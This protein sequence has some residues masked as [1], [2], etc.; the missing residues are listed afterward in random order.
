[1]GFLRVTVSR[2]WKYSYV[3]TGTFCCELCRRGSSFCSWRD[4]ASVHYHDCR[5]DRVR[6]FMGRERSS[7]YDLRSTC[8]C[9][10]RDAQER[11]FGRCWSWSSELLCKISERRALSSPCLPFPI[12]LSSEIGLRPQMCI[13]NLPLQDPRRRILTILRSDHQLT[14]KMVS[15]YSPTVSGLCTSLL[16]DLLKLADCR[17][18]A[19]LQGRS[20]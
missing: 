8:N 9:W 2:R 5:L 15:Q 1:M 17:K 18:H 19:G 12:W 13:T 6:F 7:S 14:A 20:G 16:Q 3:C 4:S 10:C 11:N